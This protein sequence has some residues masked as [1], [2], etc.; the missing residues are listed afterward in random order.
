MFLLFFN[1]GDRRAKRAGPR[2]PF[3]AP[4]REARRSSRVQH[5]STNTAEVDDSEQKAPD[6]IQK[7]EKLR[8][9]LLRIFSYEKQWV[10]LMNACM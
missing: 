8:P 10:W 6:K 4:A 7:Q 9:I 5:K 1:F 2:T 3:R